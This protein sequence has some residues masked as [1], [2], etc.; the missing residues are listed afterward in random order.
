MALDG[1]PALIET[2]TGLRTYRMELNA[3]TSADRIAAASSAR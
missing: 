2:S 1:Q 3:S